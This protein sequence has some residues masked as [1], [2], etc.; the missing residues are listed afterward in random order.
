MSYKLTIEEKSGYLHVKVTGANTK[1]NVLRYVS[2]IQAACIEKQRNKVLIEENLIGPSLGTLNIFDI[3]STKGEE[4][5]RLG[6]KLAYVDINKQHDMDVLQFGEV[7]ARNRGL[8]I[9]VFQ[10]VSEAELWLVEP[11][12]TDNHG[13]SKT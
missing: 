7:V 1:E 9:R 10:T 6:F 5:A 3:T 2:E 13:F 11:S 12:H 8:E 4:A